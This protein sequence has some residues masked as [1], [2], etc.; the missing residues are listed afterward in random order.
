LR[1]T[2]AGIETDPRTLP[3]ASAQG[4]TVLGVRDLC[5]V[6]AAAGRLEGQAF[7]PLVRFPDRIG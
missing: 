1:R 2:P 3:L 6:R 4:R 5:G 7:V